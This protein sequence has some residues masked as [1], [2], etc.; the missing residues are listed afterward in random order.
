MGDYKVISF[1]VTKTAGCCNPLQ[2]CQQTLTAFDPSA[3][4]RNREWYVET[5]GTGK[6]SQPNTRDIFSVV[7]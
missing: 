1:R 5:R 2:G 4:E 3:S 6:V 7:E